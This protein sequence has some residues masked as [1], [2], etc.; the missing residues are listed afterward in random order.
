MQN[1]VGAIGKSSLHLM[2]LV[3]EIVM[4][5][6][7]FW[8]QTLRRLHNEL[9]EQQFNLAIAPITVGE[10]NGVWIVY[11]QN[12]FKVNLLRSQYA[13]KLDAI[14]AEPVSYTHL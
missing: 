1:L 4:I 2:T 3:Y 11:A 7:D 6:A 12:Q 8:A 13:A 10:E 14:R 5:L 9:S